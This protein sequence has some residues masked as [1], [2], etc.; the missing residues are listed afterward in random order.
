MS[1]ILV[2]AP[3]LTPMAVHYGMN[4]IHFGIMMIV[5]NFGFLTHLML[6]DKEKAKQLKESLD[7]ALSMT[8]KHGNL[9]KKHNF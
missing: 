9:P 3:I 4:P 6:I 1:A 2:L 8:L 5:N 7:F